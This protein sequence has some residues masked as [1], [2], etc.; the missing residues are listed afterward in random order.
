ML[1]R[2]FC[3]LR[4]ST[5]NHVVAARTCRGRKSGED[6]YRACSVHGQEEWINAVGR[7][8]VRHSKRCFT[9]QFDFKMQDVKS[10]T[11]LTSLRKPLCFR[12]LVS[13]H[14][15]LDRRFWADYH[16]RDFLACWHGRHLCAA[17]RGVWPHSHASSAGV[18]R[19][20]LRFSL[21]GMQHAGPRA[22]GLYHLRW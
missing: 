3:L 12:M 13:V 19:G 15:S 10:R 9:A 7:A 2:V 21:A 22:A 11:Q 4:V 5:R 14:M 1:C 20:D 17:W 16:S 8:I 18:L 6:A